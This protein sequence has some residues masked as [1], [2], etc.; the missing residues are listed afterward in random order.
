MEVLVDASKTVRLTGRA[1]QD[2]EELAFKAE[3]ANFNTCLVLADGTVWKMVR[4][5][6]QSIGKLQQE[7][8]QLFPDEISGILA[9]MF[10]GTFPELGVYGY[11]AEVT[12]FWAMVARN[13]Q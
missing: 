10:G 9:H 12:D 3:V 6:R 4:G 5:K 8:C 2:A 7:I 11:R 1:K 13:L